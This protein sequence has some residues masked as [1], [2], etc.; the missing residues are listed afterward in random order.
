MRSQIHLVSG[1]TDCLEPRVISLIHQCVP[2]T[3]QKHTHTNIYRTYLTVFDRS[4]ADLVPG[5]D[6]QR[7]DLMRELRC[8]IVLCVHIKPVLPV[9]QP[10][11]ITQELPVQAQSLL[12]HPGL[13]AR[14]FVQGCRCKKYVQVTVPPLKPK[15][16]TLLHNQ[17]LG[18]LS[19]T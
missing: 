11:S 12:S 1:L 9:Q 17:L 8:F 15:C 14:L 18:N 4:L 16:L 7:E 19:K 5:Q 13:D 2:K 3:T 10:V 6:S